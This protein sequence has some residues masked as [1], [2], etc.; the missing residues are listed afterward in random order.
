MKYIKIIFV[1]F[2]VQ[3][4]TSYRLAAQSDKVILLSPDRQIAMS[5][6]IQQAK[7][8]YQVSYNGQV[9]IEQ[10]PIG[11]IVN[12]K[13]LPE[14]ISFGI[15]SRSSI[16]ESYIS[17][18]VHSKATN[19]YNQAIIPVKRIDA[20]EFSL[21]SRV[22]NNGIAFRYTVK[23]KGK[24][25]VNADETDFTIPAGSTIWS[26]RD[27]GAYEGR[28]EKQMIEDVSKGQLAG[29]P[30]T[31]QLADKL[32]YIAITEGGLT[33]FAG[34]SL[35]SAGN[36]VF[37]AN[38]TGMVNKEGLITTPWR[39]VEFGKD[40]NTL[41]NCDIINNVS[42]MPNKD[43]FPQGIATEWIHPGKSVWSWLATKHDVTFENMKEFSHE[44]G[45]LGIKY[46]LVD[47]GWSGWQDGNKDKWALMKEL[48]DYSA[49]QGVKIWAWKAYP[50]RAGV[51]GIKDAVKRLE[52]FKKCKSIGLVGLKIDF[53]DS[54]SQE[55][56][57][58]YQAALKDAAQLHLMLDF[59]GANKPTGESRTWPNEMSREGIRG[60]ENSSDWPVHNTTLPFTRYLAGH[61]DYTP[62]SFRDEIVKGTTIAH[63]VATM[64]VFTSPFMCLAADPEEILKSPAKN[65]ITTIPTVWDETIVLPQSEI[66]S[67]ALFARRSGNTWYLAGLN[68]GNERQETINL[69]FLNKGT[70][71]GTLLEDDENSQK[72]ILISQKKFNG[73]STMTFHLMQG[74]GF[75][76]R[77]VLSK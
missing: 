13:V 7:V 48:V 63:H 29:P 51:P 56:I 27:I 35:I 53:F 46:N 10:S 58:F 28:Y 55:V 70:Y 32:G 2:L 38:L 59:H 23:T 75:V 34:M 71:N 31:I 77:F 67:L 1:L 68:G 62:L 20:P 39:I 61:G 11:M 5:L 49:S 26:Q 15:V 66:G 12:Q 40:L 19:N 60:L 76:S 43:L 8:Y 16:N 57:D 24:S 21:E 64:V 42:P 17:R 6:T 73:S 74:G 30:L 65:I 50:D 72:K 37:K 69:S 44:A 18:G 9:I 25:E 4:N 14:A 45:Q 3:A 36:R 52:F 47:E 41:V 54:E 22:F 33:D